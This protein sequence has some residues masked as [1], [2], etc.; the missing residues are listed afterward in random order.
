M[1]NWYLHRGDDLWGTNI[2]KSDNTSTQLTIL[3]Q[4]EGV[5]DRLVSGGNRFDSSLRLSFFSFLF[6]V[7]FFF[8]FFFF[9][10]FFSLF[11]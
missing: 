4:R 8:F 7:F 9:L 10:V 2:A 1:I 11:F 6:S 5:G 3:A